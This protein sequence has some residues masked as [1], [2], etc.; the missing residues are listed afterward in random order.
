MGKIFAWPA[1]AALAMFS[2]APITEASAG[3]PLKPYVVLVLDTSGSMITNATGSGPPSCGGPDT[4]LNHARCAINRIVNSY[5]DIE[6]AL[7]RFRMTM[8]GTYPAC[9]QTGAG[10]AGGPTC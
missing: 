1:L 2:I 9:T 5:G 6:F 4:R 3:A 7:G 10:A 8:G